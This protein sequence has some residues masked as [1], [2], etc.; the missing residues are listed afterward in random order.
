MSRAIDLQTT[1]ERMGGF[2]F[3]VRNLENDEMWL[4]EG[5]YK[6]LG[7]RRK[8]KLAQNELIRAVVHPGDVDVVTEAL[9]TAI[10]GG[11]YDIVHRVVH[12]DGEVRLIHSKSQRIEGDLLHP[13]ILLGSIVD[14]T[15]VDNAEA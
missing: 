7:L 4:S 1:A 6:I 9:A 14:V 8:S 11:Q 15:P 13:P 5:I 10:A 2:G 12:P 3:I